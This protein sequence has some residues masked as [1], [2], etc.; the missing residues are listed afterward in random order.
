MNGIHVLRDRKSLPP[1]ATLRAFEA[2]VRL[3]TFKM[4]AEELGLT[5]SAISHQIKSLESHFQT[6]LFAR[7]GNRV[8]ATAEG[9]AYGAAVLK[10]FSELS[11]A[12][13]TLLRDG[14]Q[15]IVRVSA[16]PSFAAFAAL[17]H[18]QK[19]K[20]LNS[21]FDLRLEARNTRV[22]FDTEVVDAAIQVGNPPFPGLTAHR[23]FRTKLA[24]LAHPALCNEFPPVKTARDLAKM[25][26][27]ELS[28]IPGLWERWF[29]ASDNRVKAP[30]PSVTSDSLLAAIQM[31]ESGVGVV[32]APFPLAFS[33]VATGRLRALFPPTLPMDRPDFHLVYRKDDATTDKIKV[34]RK[35]LKAVVAE[36]ER[37]ARTHKS[38]DR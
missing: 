24:P 2:A 23:L 1:L 6:K 7:Q 12:G 25:P 38:A 31:A 28:N 33:V 13:E 15:E 5:Q 9:S 35:W 11:R 29:L 36:L 14:R 4:A 32:L 34:L 22:D 21:D 16:S 3:G 19:F 30:E 18:I 17:P 26:L 10:V 27:I 8:F 20:A 37:A